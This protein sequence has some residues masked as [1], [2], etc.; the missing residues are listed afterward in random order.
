[1]AIPEFSPEQRGNLEP[2][3]GRDLVWSGKGEFKTLDP[4]ISKL[5]PPS[6]M[7]ESLE[8]PGR[9]VEMVVKGQF[10]LLIR[11]KE[12][13][14]YIITSVR[15]PDW[16]VRPRIDQLVDVVVNQEDFLEE[17]A[18]YDRLFVAGCMRGG[19]TSFL[20]EL[21]SK[22]AEAEKKVLFIRP[23]RARKA[24][25]HQEL[26]EKYPGLII[27]EDIKSVDE[28]MNVVD[29]HS[30]DL[31]EWDEMNLL[32]FAPSRRF[33]LQEEKAAVIVKAAETM[34]KNG[35]KFAGALL[36]RFATG[37]A[38]PPINGVLTLQRSNP[39]VELFR[40][41]AQCLCGA[42]AE[43]QALTEVWWWEGGFA[44]GGECLV[45]PLVPI[46]EEREAIE[47]FYG[48]LCSRCHFM[49]HG[50]LASKKWA[51]LDFSRTRD[52]TSLDLF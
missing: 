38:F 47:N 26:L 37:E 14:G 31:I 36:D 20:R 17:G 34:I 48:P 51:N 10:G 40:M 41:Y 11:D 3:L 33:S 25:R 4:K 7:K 32:I 52:F 49:I 27:F 35:R 5:S 39:R 9:E 1:M 44:N 16:T 13:V 46:D 42:V 2:T 23:K 45:R 24:D 22:A 8:F 28:V 29:R 18:A 21:A 43:V 12:G 6:F 15:E 19:K 30:P 50:E